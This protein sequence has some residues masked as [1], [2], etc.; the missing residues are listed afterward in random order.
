INPVL[1][2][3]TQADKTCFHVIV[4]IL[5][6][7]KS[8]YRPYPLGKIVHH[9]ACSGSCDGGSPA[10]IDDGI[11]GIYSRPDKGS[12]DKRIYGEIIRI[13]Y[14][15]SYVPYV[16]SSANIYNFSFKHISGKNNRSPQPWFRICKKI[17]TVIIID[18]IIAFVF[19]FDM[20]VSIPGKA[21]E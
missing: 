14:A 17:H 10:Y 6:D 13:F 1:R 16:N 11:V 3:I 2:G 15:I 8:G 19:N 21:I 4:H 20:P 5:T 12:I 7:M 18:A 9:S